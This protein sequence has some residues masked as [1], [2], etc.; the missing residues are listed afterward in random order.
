MDF[1]GH[2]VTKLTKNIFIDGDILNCLESWDKIVK[3][4]KKGEKISP[5]NYDK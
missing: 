4:F 2:L 1:F 3:K 5:H